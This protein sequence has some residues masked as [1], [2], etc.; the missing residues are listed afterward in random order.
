MAAVL[1]IASTY[2]V[3][4]PFISFYKKRQVIKRTARGKMKNTANVKNAYLQQQAAISTT[5]VPLSY[6]KIE[7]T[8]S[9]LNLC[10]HIQDLFVIWSPEIA[11]LDHL[12]YYAYATSNGPISFACGTLSYYCYQKT[13]MAL[14]YNER[15]KKKL[16]CVIKTRLWYQKTFPHITW[17]TE[18]GAF[19]TYH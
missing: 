6:L 3:H 13:V 12:L 15:F 10:L 4:T 17:Q 11:L 14:Y 7:C 19:F 1:Y 16:T 2:V 5:L 9:R 8:Y 18:G